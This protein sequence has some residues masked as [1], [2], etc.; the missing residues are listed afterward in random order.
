MPAYVI[1]IAV[2]TD[3]EEWDEYRAIAGPAAA[4]FGARYLARG[5]DPEIVEATAGQLEPGTM[6]TIIE[7]PDLAAAH[8]WYTSD[9]Y[10]PARAISARAARRRLLF[11]EGL[12]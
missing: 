4:L 3:P 8:A 1:S 9:A 12:H 10:A 11:V 7:F 2:V 5:A 6:T